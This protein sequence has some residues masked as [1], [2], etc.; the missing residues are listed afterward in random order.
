M[1]TRLLSTSVSSSASNIPTDV[2]FVFKEEEEDGTT[3]VKDINAHKFILALV[4]DVFR[5]GFYGGF[6]DN[7]TIDIKDVKKESFEAMIDY[8]YNKEVDLSTHDLSMLCT[9]YCLG[10][11][12]NITIL[13]DESLKEIRGKEISTK[14][15]LSVG[16]LADEYANHEQLVDTLNDS[17][18]QNLSKK[19]DGELTKVIKFFEE[20]TAEASA[21]PSATTLM[22]IMGKI[23]KTPL[24]D[25]CKASP[26]KNGTEVTI[27]NFVPTATIKV[28]ATVSLNAELRPAF[29]DAAIN[30]FWFKKIGPLALKKYVNY[31]EGHN[32]SYLNNQGY[33]YVFK[34]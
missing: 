3:T 20:V 21:S 13:V 12:Y 14:D 11:K 27:E 33:V 24:C 16:L 5:T 26:C 34:C 25:N 6:Q 18:A 19:F 10:D 28:V 1:A 15:I 17:A 23:K 8:I 32:S 7:G 29:P 30:Q 4:S 9:L 2:K 22:K 31:N